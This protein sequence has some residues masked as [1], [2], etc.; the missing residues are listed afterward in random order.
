MM[1][2]FKWQLHE[3][4]IWGQLKSFQVLTVTQLGGDLREPVITYIQ[5]AQFCQF[6]WVGQSVSIQ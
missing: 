3:I 2:Y 1:S 6:T 4:K 5:F